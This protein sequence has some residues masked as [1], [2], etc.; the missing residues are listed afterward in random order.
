MAIRTAILSD[1][2][3]NL[4]ALE[5]VLADA[6]T[7]GAD[8]FVCLGDIIGF[9]ADVVACVDRVREVCAWS[10]MGDHEYNL[11]EYLAGRMKTN[12]SAE[13]RLKW[14][15]DLLVPGRAPEL[16]DKRRWDW[17]RRL[18]TQVWE[19][20]LTY[21][22]ARPTDPMLGWIGPDE[23]K[24]RQAMS[25]DF[26]LIHSWAFHGHSH[27]PGILLEGGDCKSV[28]APDVRFELTSTKKAL[29]DVGSVGQPRD[30]HAEACYVLHE[31]Q[32]VR[33]RRVTY[34]VETA[35]RKIEALAVGGRE[36]VGMR[37]RRGR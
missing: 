14:E 35:A 34:D 7:C 31:G 16:A 12:P 20:K 8:R 4:E 19:G 29:I 6:A 5:A 28:V 17:L 10:L 1:I 26:E 27:V 9:G 21:V 32:E 2:H 36:M 25:A 37:L 23:A 18:E 15:S 30:G 3:G 11:R 24:S 33:F 22:H 13:E